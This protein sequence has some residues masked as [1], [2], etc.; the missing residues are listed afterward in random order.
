MATLGSARV[1]NLDA[2]IGNFAPG[3]EFDALTVDLRAADSNVDVFDT[4]SVDDRVQK[5]L[6]S[7]DDRNIVQVHVAGR[8]VATRPATLSA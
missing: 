3:K 6:F 1:L 8:L 7:A 5:F 4:D 2:R